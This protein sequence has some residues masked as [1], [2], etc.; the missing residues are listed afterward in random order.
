[1]RDAGEHGESGSDEAPDGAGGK[2]E[3]MGVSEV[4]TGERRREY[5]RAPRPAVA[6]GGSDHARH[7][8]FTGPM[9]RRDRAPPDRAAR[10]VAKTAR[11]RLSALGQTAAGLTF[12]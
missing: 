7:N 12:T 1:M 8:R 9:R 5:S 3:G 4:K 11:T 10:G 2:P 6:T